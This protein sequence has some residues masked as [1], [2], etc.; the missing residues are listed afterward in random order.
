MWSWPLHYEK[1]LDFRVGVTF[2]LDVPWRGVSKENVQ[3]GHLARQPSPN[4]SRVAFS[5]D[6][7]WASQI[8]L[9]FYSHLAKIGQGKLS[10]WLTTHLASEEN[11]DDGFLTT[12]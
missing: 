11:L 10:L 6:V 4:G 12:F 7:P 1:R 5:L 8:F 3:L 2:S 9:T